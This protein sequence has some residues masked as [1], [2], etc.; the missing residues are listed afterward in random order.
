MTPNEL[1]KNIQQ[2]CSQS[3]TGFLSVAKANRLIKQATSNAIDEKYRTLSTEKV[4][5]ELRNLISVE[6]PYT[7]TGGSITLGQPDVTD[8][9]H[10]LAV[11]A[12]FE[13]P[14]YL[15]FTVSNTTPIILTFTKRN[16]VRNEQMAISGVVGTT[17]ANGVRWLRKLNEVNFALYADENFQTP[18][19]GNGGYVSGGTIARVF[20]EYC[21]LYRSDE[22]IG[23]LNIPT[24][25][26][27]KY[28]VANSK[29]IIRPSGAQQVS[30]DYIK[31]PTDINVTDTTTNLETIYPYK[32]LMFIAEKTA[33]LFGIEE[34]DTELMQLSNVTNQ[35]NP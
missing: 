11:K 17:N 1:Y 34:R 26:Q 4:Y 25:A 32:L 35:Q 12:Y 14:V 33:T 3:Y 18:I 24:P 31:T 6:T 27:P 16:N 7:L 2:L 21:E 8:Y 23:V 22:K 30:L 15:T 20:Y 29:L 13:D 10:L 5:D 19:A 28:E 9:L